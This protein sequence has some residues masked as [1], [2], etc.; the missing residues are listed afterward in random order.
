MFTAIDEEHGRTRACNQP[1]S[2]RGQRRELAKVWVV[3]ANLR[4]EA[5]ATP[6]ANCWVA[7]QWLF[8]KDIEK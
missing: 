6:D 1:R 7:Q 2:A 5:R 4:R 8:N 3:Q